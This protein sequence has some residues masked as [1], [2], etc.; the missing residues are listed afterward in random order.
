MPSFIIKEKPGNED[1]YVEWSSIVDA[2]TRWGTRADMQEEL[3]WPDPSAAEDA[4]F[5]RADAKGTS[6]YG[7]AE[8]IYGMEETLLVMNGPHDW[9]EDL[10]GCYVLPRENLRAYCEALDQFGRGRSGVNEAA[11]ALLRWEPYFEF[12]GP[13]DE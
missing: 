4:R 7:E 3:R 12:R 1:F 6:A 9:P 8:G 10:D 2:P 13:D 11:T 5:D